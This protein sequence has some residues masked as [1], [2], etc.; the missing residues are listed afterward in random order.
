MNIYNLF[1]LYLSRTINL[2]FYFFSTM[3][4]S[5]KKENETNISFLKNYRFKQRQKLETT[6]KTTDTIRC[7]TWN[8]HHGYDSQRRFALPQIIQYLK[9]MD[10]DVIFLQE[11][12]N[13]M[14]NIDDTTINISDHIAK[15]LDMNVSAMGELT[16]LSKFPI[17]D[18][19][20]HKT[21]YTI[22]NCSFGNHILCCSIK[23]T[24]TD[25]ITCVNIHL[26]N[27]FTGYEQLEAIKGLNLDNLILSHKENNKNLLV[28]GDFNAPRSFSVNSEISQ[29]FAQDD[30]NVA[31]TY[32][33]YY[34]IAGLDKVWLN[35]INTNQS[36]T[37]VCSD[38]SNYYSDHIPLLFEI[39]LNHNISVPALTS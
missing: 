8:I 24:Q 3:F 26:N 27:D 1:F 19:I 4:W 12:N 11:V 39:K 28:C 34:P 31:I 13:N 10:F 37:N 7:C 18:E 17:T 15:I 6:V 25:E 29:L 2:L 14:Y 16:I 22:K 9:E 33:T 21:F 38:N 20:K 30:K 36:I 35:E 23:Y 5:Y 32:P